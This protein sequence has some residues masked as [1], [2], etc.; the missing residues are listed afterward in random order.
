MIWSI[1]RSYHQCTGNWKLKLFWSGVTDVQYF[2]IMSVTFGS[3]SGSGTG[4]SSIQTTYTLFPFLP[5]AGGSDVS[6]IWSNWDCEIL[7]NRCWS[8]SLFSWMATL[9]K[10][11][12][13]KT[14]SRGSWHARKSN[15]MHQ[16][17][18]VLIWT[19]FRKL[20]NRKELFATY[21]SISVT[22]WSLQQTLSGHTIALGTIRMVIME[23]DRVNR[24]A[25]HTLV[26]QVTVYRY[27]RCNVKSQLGT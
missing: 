22:C 7:R 21:L 9:H 19:D 14:L 16:M 4:T 26:D 13:C 10:V 24:S 15:P 3:G 20:E 25:T 17:P 27:D 5:T 12:S 18:I 1:D 8:L 2:N 23:V 6:A 11:V